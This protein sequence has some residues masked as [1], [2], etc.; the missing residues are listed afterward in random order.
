MPQITSSEVSSVDID[1]CSTKS[2]IKDDPYTTCFEAKLINESNK[3]FDELDKKV[4]Q[5]A[6]LLHL[7]C[8]CANRR[9]M[10]LKIRKIGEGK[11]TIAGRNVFVRVS[12][13]CNQIL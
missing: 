4:E 13:I 7:N 11:Y 1:Q 10:K 12:I 8:R 5:A 3:G 9:Y 6:Q 2:S